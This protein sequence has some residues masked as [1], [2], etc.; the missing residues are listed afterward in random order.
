M[1]MPLRNQ[2]LGEE[3]IQAGGKDIIL[4]YGPSDFPN[5]PCFIAQRQTGKLAQRRSRKS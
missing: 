4:T 1:A 5:V 3:F 2:E